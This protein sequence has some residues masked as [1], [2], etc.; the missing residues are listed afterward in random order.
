MKKSSH[1]PLKIGYNDATLAKSQAS[2]VMIHGL[3]VGF[4][5]MFDTK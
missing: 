1:T 5:H 3:L 2:F 4:L